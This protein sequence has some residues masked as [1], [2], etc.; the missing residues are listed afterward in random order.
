MQLVIRA[1]AST[2]IGGGHVMR[3]LRLAQVF[4]KHGYDVS[5][6]CRAYPG[7][8]CSYISDHAMEVL[9]IS[10]GIDQQS[11]A[12][13]CQKNINGK[14]DVLIVDHYKLDAAWEK[15]MRSVC[16]VLLVI[17]DLWNRKHDCDILLDQNL[18]QGENPYQSLV[19]GQCHFLLG[20]KFA[21]LDAS[22][23]DVSPYV[24][25]RLR[26]RRV[27]LFFGSGDPKNYTATVLEELADRDVLVDVVIGQANPNRDVLET[28]CRDTGAQLHVQTNRMAELMTKADL[29][30]G[31]GGT[32]HLER[33]SVGL[34]AVVTAM[35]DN[36]IRLSCDLANA[37]T[38]KY[39]GKEEDVSRHHW[40]VALDSLVSSPEELQSM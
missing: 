4:R 10:G 11:D 21:L 37:G 38:C 14:A 29:L 12:K 1:D 16:N 18:L 7:D 27:L 40:R 5:F 26:C 8:M 25:T 9:P 15:Q 6:L 3:C 34:P 20:P 13:S 2:E 32:S 31:A 24:S 17:D 23:D 33:C 36:Q 30:L 22:F 19:S 35:A 28:L 39:L